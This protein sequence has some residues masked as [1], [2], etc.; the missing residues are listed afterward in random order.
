MGKTC[1]ETLTLVRGDNASKQ[2]QGRLMLSARR[3]EKGL[4]E[5]EWHDESSGWGWRK[6]DDT[7][8]E[9]G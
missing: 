3:W 9:T 7:I 4:L 5:Y 8:E 6:Q 2:L 1:G